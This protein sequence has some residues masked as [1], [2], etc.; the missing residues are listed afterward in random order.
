MPSGLSQQ[1]PLLQLASAAGGSSSVS[2][3]MHVPQSRN[4]EPTLRIDRMDVGGNETEGRGSNRLDLLSANCYD[5]NL[6]RYNDFSTIGSTY[7]LWL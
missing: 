4:K 1:Q 3:R 6:L 2:A 7:D 5:S